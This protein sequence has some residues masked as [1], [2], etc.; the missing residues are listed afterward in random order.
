MN[1]LV[2]GARGTVGS[3]VVDHLQQAGHQP[4]AWNVAEA[5]PE[6]YHAMDSF[7]GRHQAGAIIHL[8]IA[9]RSTG[10]HNEHWVINEHWPSE[11][12]WICRQ[13]HIPFVYVSTVMVFSG[14]R[15]GPYLPGTPPDAPDDSY[16]G[17]KLRV[18]RRVLQQYP[19]AHVVRIGWQM[20]RQP[21]G[22]S[23]TTHL[24]QMVHHHQ[25]IEA[26]HRWIPSCSFVHDTAI[27]LLRV[28]SRPP[29]VYHLEGNRRGW[30][31]DRI[32]RAMLTKLG[33]KGEV[34][35]VPGPAH[36]QRLLDDRLDVP[37]IEATL[38][39]HI[40]LAHEEVH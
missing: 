25:P 32:A 24:A 18:E 5:S 16:G 36:D 33:L 19:E 26:N 22:N 35:V 17:M 29:G 34:R 10:R 4:V 14:G 7:V 6:D 20:T 9:S 2:T 39:L 31:F 12:A 28:I 23:M 40:P 37:G 13:R 3:A 1:I 27:G 30:S 21:G 11:L 8:A 15:P 38:P